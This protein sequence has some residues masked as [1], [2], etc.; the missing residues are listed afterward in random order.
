M[1]AR[2]GSGEEQPFLPG[3]QYGL[4]KYP[5]LS[6]QTVFSAS[7]CSLPFVNFEL[8]H[9]KKQKLPMFVYF[10]KLSEGSY[11]STLSFSFEEFS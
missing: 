5:L 7:Q 4:C 9:D 6:L 8:N 1:G 3:M 2:G 11:T 10:Q